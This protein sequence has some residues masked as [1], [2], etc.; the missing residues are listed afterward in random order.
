MLLV[1]G[2]AAMGVPAPVIVV[3]RLVALLIVV[4]LVLNQVFDQ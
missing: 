1:W 3:L 4:R 2:L